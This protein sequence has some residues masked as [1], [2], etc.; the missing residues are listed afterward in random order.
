MANICL[1][2]QFYKGV[3]SPIVG[4]TKQEYLDDMIN[5]FDLNIDENDL[6]EIDD[7]YYPHKINCNR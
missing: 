3:A 6:K 1:S 7:L 5:C 4:I 2:W